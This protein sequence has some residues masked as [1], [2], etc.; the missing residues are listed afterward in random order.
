MERPR[1]RLRS[2]D[3]R[4]LGLP[5]MEP[6]A[7]WDASLFA[8]VAVGSSRNIIRFIDGADGRY[9]L[10]ELDSD[11]AEREW[12]VLRRCADA[13]VPAVFPVGIVDRGDGRSIVITRAVNGVDS[14]RELLARD[15]WVERIE[16]LLDALALLL[17]ELHRA[18]I[19]WGDAS[20]ANTLLAPDGDGV[21]ALLV[22]GETGEVHPD[23]LSDGQRTHD[24]ELCVERIA[25]GLADIA[26]ASGQRDDERAIELARSIP[27]RYES[28]WSELAGETRID[29][30]DMHAVEQRVRRVEQLGFTV[31]E[32]ALRPDGEGVHLSVRPGRRRAL[33]ERLERLSGVRA[34][35]GQARALLGDLELHR[36]W[37]ADLRGHAVD[38]SEAAAHWRAE[39]F[40]P[41]LARL[42]GALGTAHDPI[43]VYCE[44]LEHKWFASERAGGDVG[45]QAAIEEWLAARRA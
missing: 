30:G 23:G 44:I 8:P 40:E 32:I 45:L 2:T 18:G 19:Y 34:L 24:L 14:Y 10:K 38:P 11:W 1:I 35:E 36:A 26:A 21:V 13:G 9:A 4:L 27:T 12:R 6:L 5:W 37:L 28:I 20:L 33:S 3:E 17:V 25:H 43:Q 15:V 29:R 39:R 7:G 22:D 31:R 16:L 42:S 41:A